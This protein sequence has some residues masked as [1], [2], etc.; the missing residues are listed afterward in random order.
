MSA[1]PTPQHTTAAAI[2]RWYESKP[3]THRPHMGASLIGHECERSIWLTWRWALA[4]SFKGRILRLFSTGQREEARIVEELRG[5][6]AQVWEN[7]PDTGEQFRV[8][9]LDGHFGGSLDGIAKGLPEAPKTACVLEFKTH[10]SKSWLDLSKKKVRES[11]PQHFDQMTVYMGLMGL[12]RAMY[13]GINKDTDDIH[14]EWVHFDADR[15]H[16]L[17]EKAKRLIGMDAPPAR[18]ST[19]PAFFICGMCNFKTSCHGGVSAEANCRTCARVTPVSRGAWEC[20]IHKRELAHHEQESGCLDHLMIPALIPYATAVDGGTNWVAY[21]VNESGAGFVN[22][23]ESVGVPDG[24][25]PSFLSR[26]LHHCPSQLIDQVTELK[27]EL[28][29]SMVV[30]GTAAT[31]FDDIST[32][33]N[34]IPV[35]RDPPRKVAERK[36]VTSMLAQMKEFAA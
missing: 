4:P 3:Q 9:A 17:I 8:S 21:T 26:E 34:D 33:I 13:L 11:K 12:D 5:I 35:R 25:G 27:R 19:D 28:P 15:Y 30:T 29:G 31:D 14:S 10:S 23:H 16:F 22:A 6:G 24:F 32:D 7:D 2:V 36:K 18:I 1:L 20:G